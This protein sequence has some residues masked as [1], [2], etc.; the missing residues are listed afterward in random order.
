M[1]TKKDINAYM[2]IYKNEFG[3]ELS[4]ADAEKKAIELINLFKVIYGGQD[5]I[6]E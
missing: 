6:Q 2:Q 3:I 5:G 4:T 1:L